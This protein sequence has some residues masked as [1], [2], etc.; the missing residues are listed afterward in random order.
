MQSEGS[1]I[2]SPDFLTDKTDKKLRPSTLKRHVDDRSIPINLGY[3]NWMY[4]CADRQ[5]DTSLSKN[6]KSYKYLLLIQ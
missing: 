5:K 3:Y 1:H 4:V 2:P 6:I